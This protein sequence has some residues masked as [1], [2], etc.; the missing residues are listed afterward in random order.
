[1]STSNLESLYYIVQVYIEVQSWVYTNGAEGCNARDLG[2]VVPEKLAKIGSWGL[3]SPHCVDAGQ[4]AVHL[5]MGG[6][7]ASLVAERE[8]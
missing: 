2:P 6:A 5:R 1:M 3:Q 8:E 7:A 4:L